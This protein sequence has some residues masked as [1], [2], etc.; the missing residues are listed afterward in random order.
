M[1]HRRRAEVGTPVRL[2]ASKRGYS[3]AVDA[4]W[5]EQHP[6]TEYSLRQEVDEWGKSGMPVEIA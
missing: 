1:L 3:I 6:L 4:S 5:L 2:A